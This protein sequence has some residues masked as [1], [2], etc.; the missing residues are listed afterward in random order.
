MAATARE[1]VVQILRRVLGPGAD[2]E[3]TRL[4]LESLKMLEV[5]VALEN[6]FGVSIPEDA[7]LGRITGSVDN[8][9]AYLEKLSRA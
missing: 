6:E 2:L 5:V 7:P 4:N 1:R 3:R 8:I 9:V